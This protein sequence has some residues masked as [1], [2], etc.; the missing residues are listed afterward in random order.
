M[1][2]LARLVVV[3]A[4]LLGSPA[5][6]SDAVPLG[7]LIY[8]VDLQEA[9]LAT[10]KGQR[11]KTAFDRRANTARTRVRKKEESLLHKRSTMTAVKYERAVSELHEEIDGL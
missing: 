6:A 1:M 2:H 10:R 11:A 4:A 3:A 7:R 8:H 9:V 5:L